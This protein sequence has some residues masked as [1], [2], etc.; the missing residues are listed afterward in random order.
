MGEW[1]QVI[2]GKPIVNFVLFA[3]MFILQ[4]CYIRRI[5]NNFS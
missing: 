5:R 4:Y 3:R 2:I 1:K